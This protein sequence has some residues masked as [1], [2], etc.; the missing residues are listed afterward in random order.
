[1]LNIVGQTTRQNY[2]VSM[3]MTF[4]SRLSKWIRLQI[5]LRDSQYLKDSEDQM[6]KSIVSLMTRASIQD[7]FS[8]VTLIPTYSRFEM[9]LIPEKEKIE[10]I[11]RT[12]EI[13]FSQGFFFLFKV[14]L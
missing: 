4:F 5:R 2:Q 7:P 10:L 11:G 13:L 3:E 8:V 12:L 1:M 14:P 9:Y 6:I